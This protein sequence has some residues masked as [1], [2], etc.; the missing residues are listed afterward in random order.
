MKRLLLLSA[1]VLSAG[2]SDKPS[3]TGNPTAPTTKPTAAVKAPPTAAVASGAPT[4]AAPAGS[5]SAA[6]DATGAASASGSAAPSAPPRVWSFDKDKSDEAPV[7]FDLVN[8][9][10]KAGKWLVKGE[11]V[12]PS[13]PNVLAQL[14]GDKT[15]DRVAAAIVKDATVKDGKVS[16][17]CRIVS[18]KV[19]Q[20]CGVVFRYKDEKNY[21]LG[22]VNGLDKDVN[23]YVV[24]DG[25]RKSLGGWKGA[26]IG[27]AWHELALEGKAEHLQLSWDGTRIFE[28][29]DT[30]ITEAGR[31]GV[32][33]RADSV[34]YFDELT[35]TPQG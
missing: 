30:T 16:V 12:A 1:L 14:D 11:S 4:A 24:K 34:T 28:A 27:D 10:G 17:R 25:K 15:A 32:W 18:G 5:G 33:V 26:T 6:P 19:E 23:L 9:G 20:A 7:G 21:Y 22:R 13:A 8:L 29:S 2:C 31:I 35:L 3:P